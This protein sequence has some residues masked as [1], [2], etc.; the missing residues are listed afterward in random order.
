MKL[1]IKWQYTLFIGLFFAMIYIAVDDNNIVAR[2]IE[3]IFY[4]IA[5]LGIFATIFLV[6]RKKV[7]NRETV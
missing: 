1:N 5:W 2:S 6:L 7:R 3:N 4:Y